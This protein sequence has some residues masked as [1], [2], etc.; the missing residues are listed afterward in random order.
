MGLHHGIMRRLLAAGA[1]PT[2]RNAY[3]RKPMHIAQSKED[4]EM[5][6]IIDAAIKQK[7]IEVS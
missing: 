2:L 7:T 5:I 6:E 1:D 4:D 3:N